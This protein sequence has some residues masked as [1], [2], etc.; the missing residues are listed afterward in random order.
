MSLQSLIKNWWNQKTPV[1][2]RE[3][4]MQNAQAAAEVIQRKVQ[5]AKRNEE[6]E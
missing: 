2:K 3:F 5:E 6:K 1:Q 4:L